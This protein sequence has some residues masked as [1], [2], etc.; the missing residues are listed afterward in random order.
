[1]EQVS[2]KDEY[3]KW[4]DLKPFQ[5]KLLEEGPTTLSQA[6]LINSMWSDWQEIKKIKETTLPRIKR[7]PAFDPWFDD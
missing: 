7:Q 6:W 5:V 4:K 2:W 3:K 1:M